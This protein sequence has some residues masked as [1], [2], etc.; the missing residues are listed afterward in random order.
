MGNYNDIHVYQYIWASAWD[1]GITLGCN[2]D[3]GE[4][5]QMRRFTQTHQSLYCLHTQS[6]DVGE[7]SDQNLDL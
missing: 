7:G 6:M 1:F 5:A 4:S 3:S 2:E